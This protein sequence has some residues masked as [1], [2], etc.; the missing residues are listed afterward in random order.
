MPKRRHERYQD[1]VD[2]LF[3]EIQSNL[4]DLPRVNRLLIELTRIYDPLLS[5]R[6]VEP[7]THHQIMELL[8][9]GRRD[10]ARALLEERIELHNQFERMKAGKEGALSKEP[11]E[12]PG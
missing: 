4:D 1:I 6:V 5:G 11:H 7:S 3:G 2:K 10:E 12:I 8:R 9:S